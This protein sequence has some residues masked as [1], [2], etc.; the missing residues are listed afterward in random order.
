MRDICEA[1]HQIGAGRRG[2]ARD[3]SVRA[4][5]CSCFPLSLHNIIKI[6]S[7]CIVLCVWRRCSRHGELGNSGSQERRVIRFAILIASREQV[8]ADLSSLVVRA[9]EVQANN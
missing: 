5:L 7:Y 2:V 3:V 9:S 8:A 1:L 6:V 4:A